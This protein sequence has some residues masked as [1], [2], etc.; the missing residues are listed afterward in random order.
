MPMRLSLK[1]KTSCLSRV[2]K[3]NIPYNRRPVLG[4][5]KSEGDVCNEVCREDF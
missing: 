1:M 3:T 4:E 2:R 5:V